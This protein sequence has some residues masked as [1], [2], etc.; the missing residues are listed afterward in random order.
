MTGQA[1]REQAQRHGL[2]EADFQ[3]RVMDLAKLN[4]WR[5]VHVRPAWVRSGRMVTPYEGHPGLPDLILARRGVVLLAE[6]KSAI[7]K[8][9]ADQ[10]TWLAAAGPNGHL[11]APA[12]WPAVRAVLR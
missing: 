10:L 8:P 9:T 7:G 5:V 4:G 6:L 1:R 11:W 3:R 2:S 12:D